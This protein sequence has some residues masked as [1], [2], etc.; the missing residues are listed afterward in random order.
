MSIKGSQVQ[1]ILKGVKKVS[2]TLKDFDKQWLANFVNDRIKCNSI[3]SENDDIMIFK[4]NRSKD[5]EI[6]DPLI[7]TEIILDLLKMGYYV[8]WAGIPIQI[9]KNEESCDFEIA[10]CN[11][12]DMP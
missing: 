2:M 5:G 9:Y 1:I 12:E 3:C 7:D 8:P 10:I 6:N 11:Y 4:F